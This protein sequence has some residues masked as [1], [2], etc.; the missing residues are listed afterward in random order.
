MR[1]GA[2]VTGVTPREGN[3]GKRRIRGGASWGPV[4][5]LV[6]VV[7]STASAWL[8]LPDLVERYGERLSTV[9]RWLDDRE[10]IGIRRG[11]HKALA[12][13]AE[14]LDGLGPWLP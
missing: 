9:R 11:E 7:T 1:S 12:V 4:A 13:P 8:T 6:R 2:H 10:L 14:F 3:R 5:H